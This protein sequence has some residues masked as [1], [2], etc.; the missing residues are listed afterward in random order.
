MNKKEKK[1]RAQRR[2]QERAMFN[3]EHADEIAKNEE[4]WRAFKE[5]EEADIRRNRDF[6]DSVLRFHRVLDQCST[7]FDLADVNVSKLDGL[8]SSQEVE[9]I[10]RDEVRKFAPRGEMDRAVECAKSKIMAKCRI[11]LSLKMGIK[12][13]LFDVILQQ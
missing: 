7:P 2:N 11:A 8:I 10:V 13:D 9:N 3:I 4:R 1:T 12:P 5:K 6:N